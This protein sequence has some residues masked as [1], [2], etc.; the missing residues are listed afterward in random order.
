MGQNIQ[1]FVV[2]TFTRLRDLEAKINEKH[3]P[4]VDE[5]SQGGDFK[6]R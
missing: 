2:W 4:E 6:F 5:T 3:V 1:S